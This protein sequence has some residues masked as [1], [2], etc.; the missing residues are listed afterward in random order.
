LYNSSIKRTIIQYGKIKLQGGEKKAKRFHYFHC[1]SFFDHTLKADK[2]VLIF[3]GNELNPIK[4]TP[5]AKLQTELCNY[6]AML[7][8][9]T[10]LQ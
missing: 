9:Q 5:G 6:I 8:F 2:Q 4:E 7:S 3:L 1:I 10:I